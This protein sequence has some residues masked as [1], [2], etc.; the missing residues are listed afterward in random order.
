MTEQ[1]R[2]RAEA[3]RR[4]VAAAG[5]SFAEFSRRTGISRNIV[6]RLTKGQKPKPADQT[7]LEATLGTEPE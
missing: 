2:Q 4:R 3:F 7:K 1:E 6:Y 5:L